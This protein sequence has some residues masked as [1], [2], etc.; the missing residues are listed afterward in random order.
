MD[1]SKIG[2][3]G[4]IRRLEAMAKQEGVAF[5][6]DQ[7]F[8]LV[9]GIGDDAAA[10][11]ID[12]AG[13]IELSTTDTMVEEIH[14]TRSTTP[15]QDVGWKAMASNLSDIAA[16][17]GS[18]TYTLVTLGLPG[19]VSVEDVEAA[20]QGVVQACKTYDAVIA[21]GDVVSSPFFFIT[22]ALNGLV[23]GQLMRRSAAVP[24][25]VIAVTGPLG[26]SRGGL[27]LMRRYSEVDSDAVRQLVQAHRHPLP[28]LQEGRVL[29][30]EGVRAAMDVS[31]GL[32]D[33]L[34]KMMLAS[35]TA[36]R[37]FSKDIA[38]HPALGETLPGDALKLALAGGEEYELLFTASN[39][40]A[41]RIKKR[42]PSVSIIGEVIVGEAGEVTVYDDNG[43]PIV[44]I[45]SG[46][47]HLR[48]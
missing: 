47:D 32:V 9:A 27:E 7:A 42:L 30:E 12:T 40:V 3:F 14:F 26:L 44:D 34:E 20:F 43:S 35:G 6:R 45:D 23:C 8:A 17:G 24:G 15:W 10:W 1:L 48:R 46:W 18:P 5:S 22:I 19:N 25:D 38:I 2:E 4:L 16:M 31:D 33:D 28:R 39:H 29:L 37:I 13:L 41:Q 21:G 36:A 11:R